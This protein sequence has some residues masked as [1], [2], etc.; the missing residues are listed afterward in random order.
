MYAFLYS[1]I[2]IKKQTQDTQQ[3]DADIEK[4]N[5]Q[6]SKLIDEVK[7]RNQAQIKQHQL[8]KTTQKPVDSAPD[9]QHD[10]VITPITPLL[11]DD[12]ATVN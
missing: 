2:F 4:D 11:D 8:P 12:T 7:K 3:L 1:Q 6:L 10:Y 5:E 9:V